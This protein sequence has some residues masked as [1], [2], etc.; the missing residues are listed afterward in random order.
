MTQPTLTHDLGG[1]V[2]LITGGT[3]AIGTMFAQTLLAAGS[4]V[5]VLGRGKTTPV[6]DAV[7]AIH[8]GN[9]SLPIYGFECDTMDE[10]A[11]VQVL[12]QISK[13]VGDPTV[14][15]NAAGGNRGKAPFTEVDTQVFDEVVKMNL[16]G[17]LVIPTKHVAALWI[18]KNIPGIVVNVTSMTSYKPLS[19]VWAYNASKSAVL[20]MT[21]GL[22]Q[23]L[24]PHGIRVNAIAPGF[25]VGN[26]NKALLYSDYDKGVLTDRGK[27][28]IGRTPF[29]RF[30]KMEELAGALLFLCDSRS[31]GFITG[32]SIPV[33]GGYLCNNI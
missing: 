19:G 4:K 23:E 16:L 7:A 27:S 24:A 13:E 26:Q 20:N 5:V 18:Q 28:I 31:S 29:G 14:L 6:A 17:G 12:A 3:G 32:V 33:D 30:G 2:A 11:F 8:E 15:V 22:A 9:I 25:F 1:H 10:K 21:E